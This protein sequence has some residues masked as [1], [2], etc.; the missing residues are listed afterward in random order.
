MEI[1]ATVTAAQRMASR[2][3]R[4]L[5][6]ILEKMG[7]NVANTSMHKFMVLDRKFHFAIYENSPNTFLVANVSALW[8]RTSISQFI[9][10]WDS[11]RAVESLKEHTQIF[12]A[13][14]NREGRKA[15][16]LIREHKERSLNRLMRVL[17]V[18]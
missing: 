7:K 15:G 12:E 13:I 5:E 14:R 9:F 1:L 3:F 18:E 2:A 8:D 4:K 17:G 11:I 16:D 6:T 10:A